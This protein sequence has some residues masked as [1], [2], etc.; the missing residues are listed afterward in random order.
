MFGLFKK[1]PE[2]PRRLAANDK[3][4]AALM[5]HGD[6]GA[7]VRHV[8]HFA[9]PV[10]GGSPA[11]KSAVKAALSDG[12]FEFTET[13]DSVGVVFEHYREV[14]SR[15]FDDLT[16]DLEQIMAGRGWTYDGWECAVENGDDS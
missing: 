5:E 7:R 10:D 14:A 13:A 9:Y 16:L 3:V 2:R 11:T 1:K 15:E 8:I 12:A 6:N 4:R